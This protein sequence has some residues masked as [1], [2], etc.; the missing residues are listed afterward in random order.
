MARNEDLY[1]KPV[2]INLSLV[3]LPPGSDSP[4]EGVTEDVIATSRDLLR[5]A[6]QNLADAGG[7]FV[8]SADND[9]DPRDVR[10]NPLEQR[11]EARY[12]AHFADD[13]VCFLLIFWKP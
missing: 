10:M 11:F 4:P 13:D 2:V 7:V 6:M 3:V 9:S 1:Q 8:A 5:L 12:P